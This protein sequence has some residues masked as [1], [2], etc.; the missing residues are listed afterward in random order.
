M[1]ALVIGSGGREHALV[2][3]LAASPKIDQ[4][5]AAPGNP[6]MVEAQC[7][8]VKVSDISGLIQL[9]Q[10][11]G[12]DLT[13]VGPEAPLV[14]GVVDAFEAA[15]LNIFG[16]S[17]KAAALEGSKAFTKEFL[18]KYQ[19][20]TARYQV[21]HDLESAK[22]FVEDNRDREWVVKVDGLAAGKGVFVT[23]TPEATLQ[24]LETVFVEK[25]FGDQAVVIEEFL[26]GEEV[27]FIALCD[28][29][30]A[31]PL[32]S[33]QDHKRLLDGDEGPNTGGMG[34]Y[35]PA[36]ILTPELHERVMTRIIGPTLKGM[37]A[38]GRAFKGVLYA[39]LM[40]CDGEP[41]VLEY[42]VRFGDPEAQVI[43]P[44]LDSDWVDLFLAATQ[45]RLDQVK[46]QWKDQSAVVIVLAAKGYPSSPQK[47]DVISG[48]D[49]V[50]EGVM[51]YHAGTAKKGGDFV[52]HG[53]RVLG[54]TALGNDL[55]SAVNRAYEAVAKIHFDGMQFRKD[56]AAKG[57]K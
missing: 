38:E 23:R 7:H 10:A 46:C 32:A 2:K 41:L 20:P 35:S 1:K 18:K 40:I 47:G 50:G 21:C 57:L 8:P 12:V 11:E 55:Q 27:S 25:A 4:V 39:G 15:G 51:V 13:V 24:A 56:I 37:A 22:K 34:A 31:L 54:V 45:G 6:G 19:I 49:A 14:E 29:E 33:S 42:N 3:A 28:G 16:A 36:P 44:R 30:R 53:G 52:T 48:L 9:A 43:L 26:D 17:Q 5:L